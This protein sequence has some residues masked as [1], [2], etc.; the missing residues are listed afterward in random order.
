[1]RYLITISYDGSNYYGFQRLNGKR[2]IQN[3]IEQALSKINKKAVQIKGAGR[4]DALVHAYGQRASFDLDYNIPPERLKNAINS[5]VPSD[6]YIKDCKI[7]DANF[8]A[9]FNVKEKTYQYKINNGEYDPLKNN[10][11]L[12]IPTKINLNKLRESAKLF[13]GV[14]NF[15][16]FVSG[17][18]LNYVAIIY[19]IS[20]LK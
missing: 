5:L 13:I 14:N 19:K 9:R 8:H 11:Y 2:T 7:V 17:Y 18:R 4:T 3:E 10:Y 20:V 1:M 15:K 6:I 16:N 12:H